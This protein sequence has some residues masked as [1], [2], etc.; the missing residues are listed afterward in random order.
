MIVEPLNDAQSVCPRSPPEPPRWFAA[1]MCRAIA[2]RFGT[3]DELAEWI[4]SLP[5]RNDEGDP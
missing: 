4:G 1:P 3:T 5:Q 2:G